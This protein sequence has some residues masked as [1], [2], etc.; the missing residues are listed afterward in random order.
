M[1]E[2]RDAEALRAIEHFKDKEMTLNEAWDLIDFFAG[3]LSLPENDLASFD[4]LY[5][6]LLIEKTTY[7]LAVTDL[8]KLRTIV[9]KYTFGGEKLND[10]DRETKRAER[11]VKKEEL[12][13]QREARRKARDG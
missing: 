9:R 3:R 6:E 12:E 7:R 2:E 13:A 4:S 8:E 11:A 1:S 10:P 5:D